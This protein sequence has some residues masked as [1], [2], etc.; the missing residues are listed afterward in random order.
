MI[1]IIKITQRKNIDNFLNSLTLSKDY[2]E[3]FL[4]NLEK[5]TH[6]DLA[7]QKW[8]DD[9]EV[10]YNEKTYY[11]EIYNKTQ[12][13][14]DSKYGQ[15]KE[16]WRKRS[17]NRKSNREKANKKIADY[18]KKAEK[19]K[20]YKIKNTNKN[21]LTEIDLKPLKIGLDE[22]N[23]KNT[24]ENNVDNFYKH[25]ENINNEDQLNNITNFYDKSMKCYS[26][27]N[28]DDI[29]NI[30]TINKDYFE[31]KSN[32][33]KYNIYV[34]LAGGSAGISVILFL[35]FASNIVPKKYFWTL[36][37]LFLFSLIFIILMIVFLVLAE[38]ENKNNTINDLKDLKN[39]KLDKYYNIHCEII[40]EYNKVI[41]A[42]L[43]NEKINKIKLLIEELQNTVPSGSSTSVE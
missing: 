10:R 7:N 35:L 23:K 8:G 22:F 15:E 27:I 16:K 18:K 6:S 25:I 37:S 32:S 20:Y 40:T 41:S 36:R 38:N 1:H 17:D 11:V 12:K 9:F 42:K 13:K 39:K 14:I 30:I 28:I 33:K 5:V 19:Y 24:N 2:K 4:S 3:K 43:Y 21:D 26:E 29:K 34:G 31:K